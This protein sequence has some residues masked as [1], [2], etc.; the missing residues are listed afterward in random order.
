MTTG[1]YPRTRERGRE[2]VRWSP[3]TVPDVVQALPGEQKAYVGHSGVHVLVGLEPARQVPEGLWVPENARM[4]WHLSISHPDR[5]PTWDEVADAR[6][7]F[8]PASITMAMLLPPPERYLNL[9]EHV[10]HLWQIDDR[11]VDTGL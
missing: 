10:F 1:Q 8:C 9:H 11:R 4:L 7:E 2:P 5:Y 3:A 6:Y